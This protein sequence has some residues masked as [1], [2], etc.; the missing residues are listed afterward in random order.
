[1]VTKPSVAPPGVWLLVCW[2]P[3]VLHQHSS[4]RVLDIFPRW[5]HHSVSPR[6]S[7]PSR[8]FHSARRMLKAPLVGTCNKEKPLVG[9]LSGTVKLREGSLTALAATQCHCTAARRRSA[10]VQRWS[11]FCQTNGSL[12]SS[13]HRH[14]R[15]H[16]NLFLSRV[17]MPD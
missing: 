6:C 13:Q 12:S 8:S 4:A 15:Q 10:G 3:R 1:M 2:W 11:Q 9:A 17:C 7:K 16:T 5:P 14:S